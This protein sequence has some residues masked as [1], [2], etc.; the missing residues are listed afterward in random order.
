MKRTLVFE[1]IRLAQGDDILPNTLLR[2]KI[3]GGWIIRDAQPPPHYSGPAALAFVPDPEHT[4]DG[5][6]DN[7]I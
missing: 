1:T 5:N 7:P 2:A 6:N 3:P 4:W